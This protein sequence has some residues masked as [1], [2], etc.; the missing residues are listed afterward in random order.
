MKKLFVLVT[1]AFA[2]S[3]FAE[4]WDRYNNPNIYVPI[5]PNKAINYNFASLPLESQLESDTLGWSGHY[6]PF[7]YGGITYRWNQPGFKPFSNKFP[8]QAEILRMTEAQLAELSPAELYDIY[9]GDYN[10]TFTKQ[11]LATHNPKAGWWE[12]LCDGWALSA[13]NYAEPKPVTMINKDGVRVPFGSSDVKALMAMHGV[14][15]SQGYYVKVGRRCRAFGRVAGEE[16]SPEE[17][18]PS[19]RKAESANCRDVNAGAFH[20][21]ITNMLGIHN[22]SFVADV[23]RYGE[24]WNQ[25][26]TGYSSKVIGEVNDFSK[27]EQRRGVAKKVRVQ[28]RMGYASELMFFSNRAVE[29]GY[30]NFVSKDPVLN[31][32]AQFDKHKDYEYILELDR[33]GN[34]IGGEWVTETRP[35]MMWTK[36]RDARFNDSKYPLSSL[37]DIYKPVNS[38]AK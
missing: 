24:V 22:M 27:S 29:L 5:M 16:V 13:A 15:N 28:T 2:T 7:M 4:G 33:S 3:V 21:V 25:P 37:N 12:G 20:V 9:R 14:Y 38:N 36:A 6:W 19:P 31:T 1:L 35:D 30:K 23:D 34:I 10:F 17:T 8:T 18:Q 32:P 26:V 11:L